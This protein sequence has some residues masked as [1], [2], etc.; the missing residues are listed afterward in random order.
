MFP[1]GLPRELARVD[2]A[3]TALAQGDVARAIERLDRHD[4]DVPRPELAAEVLRLRVEAY[5][6][7]GD[8][9]R[10]RALAEAF[11][12]RYP[13]HPMTAHIRALLDGK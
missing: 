3:R 8:R 10:V 2:Q 9:V 12:L 1:A 13:A 6:Q 5:A 11:L 4:L 7:R